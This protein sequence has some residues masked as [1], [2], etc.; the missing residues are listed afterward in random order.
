MSVAE[1]RFRV[2]EGEEMTDERIETLG[3][4]GIE[5]DDITSEEDGEVVV[6]LRYEDGLQEVEIEAAVEEVAEGIMDATGDMD[7]IEFLIQDDL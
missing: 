5:E 3:Q 6:R 4:I 7:M 2:P 1:V